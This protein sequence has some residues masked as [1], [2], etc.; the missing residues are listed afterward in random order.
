MKNQAT[1]TCVR[2]K[3]GSGVC[4]PVIAGLILLLGW[5]WTAFAM[6]CGTVTVYG[7]G[8]AGQVVFDGKLH[9][10]KGL[11]CVDCH[12]GRAFSSAL[13]EMKKGAD[14][15]SMRKMELGRSC[16]YCHPVSMNDTLT[17]DKCHK[18]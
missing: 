14:V 11:N 16:G 5:S 7:G 17:C 4:S 12:E 2:V 13:F 3:P 9:S 18:K 10:E 8:G 6:S 15:M 1:K